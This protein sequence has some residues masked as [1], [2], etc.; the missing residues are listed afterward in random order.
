MTLQKHPEHRIMWPHGFSISDAGD[1]RHTTHA[2]LDC[3][4]CVANL[5]MVVS[6]DGSSISSSLLIVPSFI[7]SFVMVRFGSICFTSAFLANGVVVPFESDSNS[8]C[9]LCT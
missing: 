3:S 7:F 1:M 9:L 8:F 5:I 6:S 4:T 2:I